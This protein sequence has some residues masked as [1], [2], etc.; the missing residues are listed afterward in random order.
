MQLTRQEKKA[1]KMFMKIHKVNPKKH[2]KL[3]FETIKNGR[4]KQNDII[5]EK[6]DT[7]KETHPGDTV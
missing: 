7:A 5:S 6:S 1:I 2:R 4:Q 3:F